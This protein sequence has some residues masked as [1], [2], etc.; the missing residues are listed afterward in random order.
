M[1]C[2]A[3]TDGLSDVI[4]SICGTFMIVY[5]AEGIERFTKVICAVLTGL[6]R[7]SLGIMCAHLIVLECVDPFKLAADIADGLRISYRITEVCL[8]LAATA[9]VTV[10]LYFIPWISRKLFPVRFS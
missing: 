1:V 9:V 8:L 7:I 3:Y 5:L 10:I 2:N 4:G 6:G